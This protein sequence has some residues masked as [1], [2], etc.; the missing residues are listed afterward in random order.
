MANLLPDIRAKTAKIRAETA[1]R[2]LERQGSGEEAC[3]ALLDASVPPLSQ[4]Y[5]QAGLDLQ[6]RP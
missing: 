3:G 6:P 1:D 4:L 2:W 5:Q